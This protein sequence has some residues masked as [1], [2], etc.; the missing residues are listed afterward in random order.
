M[1]VWIVLHV[2]EWAT[3]IDMQVFHSHGAAKSYVRSKANKDDYQ[4]ISRKVIKPD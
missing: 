4:I 2:G 3:I 1:T